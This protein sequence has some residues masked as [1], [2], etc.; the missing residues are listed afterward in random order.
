MEESDGERIIWGK[1]FEMIRCD[2]CGKHYMTKEQYDYICKKTGYD[3]QPLC[4]A[5]KVCESCSQTAI[6]KK[7]VG[8]LKYVYD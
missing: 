8:N 1:K 7:W 5:N 4:V 6:A 2:V 3:G